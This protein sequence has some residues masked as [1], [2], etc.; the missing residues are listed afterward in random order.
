MVA[1]VCLSQALAPPYQPDRPAQKGSTKDSGRLRI[2]K[3]PYKPRRKSERRRRLRKRLRRS[4]KPRRRRRGTHRSEKRRREGPQVPG[5]GCG[6]RA[7]PLAWARRGR[8]PSYT[9][10]HCSSQDHQA[11]RV[12]R[13][14]VQAA[15]RRVLE[16]PRRFS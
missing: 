11:K 5:A 16:E 3:W 13:L 4:T 2:P 7:T 8:Q 6:A 15:P 10:R 14:P 9:S 12:S 1:R